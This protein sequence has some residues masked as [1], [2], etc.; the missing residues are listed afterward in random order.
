[1]TDGYFFRGSNAFLVVNVREVWAMVSLDWQFLAPSERVPDI[2]Y[3]MDADVL[4]S[5]GLSDLRSQAE[6]FVVAQAMR[7]VHAERYV[8]LSREAL[9]EWV[10]NWE[11]NLLLSEVCFTGCGRVCKVMASVP[12]WDGEPR[13]WAYVALL[14]NGSWAYVRDFHGDPQIRKCRRRETRDTGLYLPNFIDSMRV[15]AGPCPP[16]ASYHK[17]EHAWK[18]GVSE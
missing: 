8:K 4:E 11:S 10:G 17:S 6:S 7:G 16:H 2:A 1:M 9:R 14:H 13:H 15:M 12:H 18:L 3:R 5:E